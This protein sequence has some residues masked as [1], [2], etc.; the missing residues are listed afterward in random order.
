MW[1]WLLQPLISD[2]AHQL[3]EA[4]QWHARLMFVAWGVLAPMSVLIARFFK[5]LPTQDW[6]RQLDSQLWWRTHWVGQSLAVVCSFIAL[7]FVYTLEFQS[8][9]ARI[10]YT[11]LSL[12]IVQVALGFFRGSKGGPTA[13]QSNGN[14]AGD[15]YDMNLR[16]RLFELMH[17]SLGYGLLAMSMAAISVGLWQVNAPR[18][19]CI[20]I[21]LWWS[22]LAIAF[23]ML[24]RK[25]FA[26][27]TYQ[28]IWGPDSRHP[29]NNM[30]PAGWGM[31]RLSDKPVDSRRPVR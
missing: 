26:I 5:V 18:W 29:G 31:R 8:L 16:R 9:H 2:R 10:G 1:E 20:A 15:H 19:M 25:G 13:P 12:A 23:I 28:A 14:L 4:Q 22:L 21:T 11:V 24:Q 6:P 27:D 17:K 3:T 7:V 30:P